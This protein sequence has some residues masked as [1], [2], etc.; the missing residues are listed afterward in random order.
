KN[1]KK[2][3]ICSLK[4]LIGKESWTKRSDLMELK[5]FNE[6]V[7]G[8]IAVYLAQ[9]T[10]QMKHCINKNHR[11]KNKNGQVVAQLK[12]IENGCTTLAEANT[13]KENMQLDENNFF[14]NTN[15]QLVV[16]QGE[17]KDYQKQK[18]LQMIGKNKQF[19]LIWK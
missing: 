14:L 8:D 10:T 11:R 4:W 13:E 5:Q 9:V 6:T 19:E 15:Q 3:L 7:L 16:I 1:T 12:E 2:F 17:M 18:K